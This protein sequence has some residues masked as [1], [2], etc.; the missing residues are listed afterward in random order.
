MRH[1]SKGCG[2]IPPVTVSS[3]QVPRTISTGCQGPGL[4]SLDCQHPRARIPRFVSFWFLSLLQPAVTAS[5]RLSFQYLEH[6]QAVRNSHSSADS[7][8]WIPAQIPSLLLFCVFMNYTFVSSRR[9]SFA[10]LVLLNFVNENWNYVS[11]RELNI[12]RVHRERRSW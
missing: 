7:N 10:K 2:T 6:R 11:Y 8:I 3:S 12:Q 4:T 5:L 9:L 1:S